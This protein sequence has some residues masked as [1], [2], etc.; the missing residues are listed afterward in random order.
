[1]NTAEQVLVIMLSAALAIFLICA[2]IATV[3]V[4]QILS[5]VKSLT[6]KAEALADKAE[7]VGEFFK[8]SAGPVAL[9]KLISNIVSTKKQGRDKE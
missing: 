7:E 6:L 9:A 8:H 2:I 1:M 4:I 5:H 3:K